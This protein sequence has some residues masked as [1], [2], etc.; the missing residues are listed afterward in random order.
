M[1][2]WTEGTSLAVAEE[3]DRGTVPTATFL[4]RDRPCAPRLVGRERELREL[5]D[6]VHGARRPG[7]AWVLSAD[8]GSGKSEL[9]EAAA[10]MAVAAGLRVLRCAGGRGDDPQEYAGVDRLLAGMREEWTDFPPFGPSSS[11]VTPVGGIP[12]RAERDRLPY[13]VLD[14]M[15]RAGRARPL[16]LVVDDW[17]T[18]DAPSR[19]VLSFV[20]R[21]AGGQAPAVLIASR[22]HP[23]RLAPLTGI[24]T[25]TIAPLTAVQ[26]LALLAQRRAGNGRQA[27]RELLTA[28]GGNPLTLLELPVRTTDPLP[29][30]PPSSDRLVA[31][32]APGVA[33]LPSATGDLLLVAALHPAG[34]LPRLLS[35]ASRLA[36]EELGFSAVE[37]AEREGLVECDGTRLRFTHP[38]MPG[39]VTHQTGP[40]RVRAAHAALSAVSEQDPVRMLWHLSQ[41][42]RGVDAQ[43]A[44]RLHAVHRRALEGDEPMLAVRLLSRAA[45][46]HEVPEDRGRCA[47]L[48]AQLAQ[49]LGRERTARAMA[50]RAL[51]FPLTPPG[52][53]YAEALVLR[54]GIRWRA[55]ADWPAPAGTRGEEDAMELARFSAPSMAGDAACSEALLAFLDKVPDRADDPRLLYAVATVAAPRRAMTV[56]RRV[57]AHRQSEDAPVHVLEHLGEAAWLTGDPLRALELHRRAEGR[58]RLHER[59]DHLP[60]V[61]L[62]QGLCHVLTGDWVQA[63]RSFR[64]CA[65]LG[66]EHGHA[67]HAATARLLGDLVRGLR[68]GT[69]RPVSDRERESARRSVRTVD[70]LVTLCTGWAQVEGGD[71]AAGFA[72]LSALLADPQPRMAAL[73]ALVPFA[74][75][76]EAAHT[77]EEARAGLRGFEARMGAEHPPL[78]AAGLSVA[79]ALVAEDDEDTEARLARAFAADLSHAPFLEASRR[80]AHGRL[81]RRRN[82]V[83]DFRV[84]VRQAA[85]TF[86]SAGAEARIARITEEL[87][88]SGGRSD[89]GAPAAEEGRTAEL[90]GPQELRIARLAA[91]G[92]SNRQI[93]AELGLSHRTIGSYLYRIFPRLGVTARTQLT[94]ALGPVR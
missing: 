61:L 90:L 69:V 13:A 24:P 9:L 72:T 76:A 58:H 4:V 6:F 7:A 79:W 66:A 57:S 29:W 17:D 39:A 15:E 50:H 89:G 48:A 83:A 1:S 62:Q 63:E 22:P 14:L 40:R 41:A 45:D 65:V 35:A 54:D 26:S 33:R 59:A 21:R 25:T 88:A 84:T 51:R 80:L 60:W 38:A 82:E 94:D 10:E 70:D 30:I 27:E 47:L 28:A 34:E 53:L 16:L 85:A 42:V 23:R 75:A 87:R 44:H 52:T 78:A 31:A 2:T 37:P 18:L 93:G 68:T 8:A 74:Q 5:R 67:D 32:L 12:G 91:Q 77:V 81:L 64:E 56:V 3:A 49:S 43:L 20:A 86:R 11:P 92:M 55:P 71:F 73:F 36:G 19:E 46:L